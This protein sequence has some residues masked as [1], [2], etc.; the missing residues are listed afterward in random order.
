M[1]EDMN[2]I[3]TFTCPTCDGDLF[4]KFNENVLIQVHGK[5][6]IDVYKIEISDLLTFFHDER[7]K[8][9]LDTLVS[10]RLISSSVAKE[11]TNTFRWGITPH[12]AL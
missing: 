2:K 4:D 6:I 10:F 11:N 7:I 1:K 8:N 3:Y 9:I 12:K 5:N